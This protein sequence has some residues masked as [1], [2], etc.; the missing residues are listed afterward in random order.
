MA[1]LFVA[2]T[3]GTTGHSIKSKQVLGMRRLHKNLW[4]SGLPYPHRQGNSVLREEIRG[5]IVAWTSFSF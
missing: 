1:F 2:G 5:L 3:Q 4:K